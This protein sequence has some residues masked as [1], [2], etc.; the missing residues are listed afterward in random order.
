MRREAR[1]L[2][3]LWSWAAHWSPSVNDGSPRSSQGPPFSPTGPSIGGLPLFLGTVIELALD[4]PRVFAHS[5]Q[6]C[7]HYNISIHSLFQS[8]GDGRH[9]TSHY[10]QV[11]QI[12]LFL[13]ASL[14]LVSGRRVAETLCHQQ[15]CVCHQHREKRKKTILVSF[16]ALKGT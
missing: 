9:L 15:C 4:L 8:Q 1:C 16:M 12:Q 5:L 14:S 2:A 3:G 7:C 6:N 11:F 10:P 13:V